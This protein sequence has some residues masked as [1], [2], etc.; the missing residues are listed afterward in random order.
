M[1]EGFAFHS[2]LVDGIPL[3]RNPRSK[4]LGVEHPARPMSLY[5]SIWDASDSAAY[6][7]EYRANY[8]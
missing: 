2:F 3:R 7:G 1:R 8:E 5:G 4:A 6:G